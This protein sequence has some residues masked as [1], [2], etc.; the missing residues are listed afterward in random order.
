MLWKATENLRITVS[1]DYT[2]D[3][4]ENAADSIVS[5]LGNV[6]TPNA[7]S[8][9]AYFGVAYDSRF[10]TGDPYTTYATYNDPI[11]AGT[12]IPGN[13]FYNGYQVNGTSV[14]GGSR[15]EPFTDLTNWGVSAKVSWDITPGI[16]FLTVISRRDL[17][18]TQTYDDDGSPLNLVQ[19]LNTNTES[20]WTVES[21]LSGKSPF[22]DW[23][24]GRL[25]LHWRWPP[26]GPLHLAVGHVPAVD[27]LDLRLRPARP[28]S[29]MPRSGPSATSGGSTSARATRT[30]RRWSIS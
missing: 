6:V 28:C 1:G 7:K 11:T 16:N 30:T 10:V 18:S 25:L 23:V 29:R 27:Q 19:R 14:R 5:I 20:Y 9:A 26:E 2:H 13:T 8:A 21:R 12:V 15:F 4:S 3:T 24:G 22:I 17:D